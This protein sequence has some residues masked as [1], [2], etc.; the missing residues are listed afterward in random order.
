[1]NDLTYSLVSV[2]TGLLVCLHVQYLHGDMIQNIV[3]TRQIEIINSDLD[4]VIVTIIVL[5]TIIHSFSFVSW[6]AHRKRY[7]AIVLPLQQ[8]HNAAT[9]HKTYEHH[10]VYTNI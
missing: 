5:S 6:L 2:R 9:E 7:G 1:M 8:I 10:D 4:K 3:L